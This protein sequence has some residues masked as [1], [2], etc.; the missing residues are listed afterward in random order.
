MNER[1]RL[2]TVMSWNVRGLGDPEKCDLVRDAVTSAMPLICCL[3]ETKLPDITTL[4]ARCFLPTNLANSFKLISAAGSR[5]GILTAWNDNSFSLKSFIT[6]QHSLTTILQSTAT[7]VQ[8]MI[9][10]VYAP[11][12]HRDSHLFL[13]GL[14][15]LSTHVSDAWLVVGDFNLVRSASDKN[16]GLVSRSLC[17]AF[18]DARSRPSLALNS[19]EL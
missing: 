10:N 11:S 6:R 15:E 1:C 3:Q 9:T 8:I 13:E 16:N 5:G 17:N 2:F 18:N 14:L 7:D 12:D 19:V 4:K